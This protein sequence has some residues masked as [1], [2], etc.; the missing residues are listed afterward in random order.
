MLKISPSAMRGMGSRESLSLGEKTGR[1][2]GSQGATGGAGESGREGGF[3][4]K[5]R[6]VSLVSREFWRSVL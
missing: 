2:G 5:L 3:W 4:G 1:R 6:T